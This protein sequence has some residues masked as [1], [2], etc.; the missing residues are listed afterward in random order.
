ML[1]A[2]R[3][4]LSGTTS[5]E[6]EMSI[7]EDNN[8]TDVEVELVRE[9]AMEVENE[10]DKLDEEAVADIAEVKSIVTSAASALDQITAIEE[11]DSNDAEVAAGFVNITL[12]ETA[13]KIGV[14]PVLVEVD[15]YGDVSTE[16]ALNWVSSVFSGVISA[17]ARRG[18]NFKRTLSG[19][20]AS[21][22]TIHGRLAKL[23]SLNN[24]RKGDG[25]EP[26]DLQTKYLTKLL[27]DSQYST[28]PVEDVLDAVTKAS[29]ITAMSVEEG[30]KFDEEAVEA[31]TSYFTGKVTSEFISFNKDYLAKVRAAIAPKGQEKDPNFKYDVIGNRAFA[32]PH[33]VKPTLQYK[34]IEGLEVPSKD[35]VKYLEPIRSMSKADINSGIDVIRNKILPLLD[36][37]NVANELVAE[38]SE[39]IVTKLYSISTSGAMT[40]LGTNASEREL[41]RLV[42]KLMDH[43][44]DS[45]IPLYEYY[46]QLIDIT[47]ALVAYMEES[48]IQD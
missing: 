14:D 46:S 44:W 13:A 8:I 26:I 30:K 22:K 29:I 38:G 4:H 31:V 32:L 17:T 48:T 37:M 47:F 7:K 15:E 3:E 19:L 21:T 45:V 27:K 1:S 25:G 35:V 34:L 9:E 23:Q 12:G 24:R 11:M 6:N 20:F 2:I 28:S 36:E 33:P 18:R 40:G 41:N 39:N 5:F 10:L 42:S 43:G 16:G